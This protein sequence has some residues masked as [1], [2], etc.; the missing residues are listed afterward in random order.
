MSETDEINRV[1]EGL[2]LN[3]LAND[4]ELKNILEKRRK[5]K[6]RE[7]TLMTENK[8]FERII[9]MLTNKG[10]TIRQYIEKYDDLVRKR[11]HN[12]QDDKKENSPG[13]D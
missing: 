8:D 1:V 5:I 4:D 10:S 13:V 7:D 2:K 3:I 12:P 6:I 11:H 9:G